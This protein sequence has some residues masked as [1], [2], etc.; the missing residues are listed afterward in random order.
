LRPGAVVWPSWGGDLENTHEGHDTTINA[1]NVHMLRQKWVVRT[2]GNISAIPTLSETR[3][4]VPDWGAP[5][6]G[7]STLYAIDRKSGHVVGKRHMRNYSG[8]VL[9]ALT[10]SS[11]A[12]AGDLMVF[13]DV[14]SQA[15]SLLDL[16]GAHGAMVYAVERSTGRLVWKTK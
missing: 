11:P 5:Y 12:L 7:E 8:N 1:Q 10:R 6:L 13:G 16:P 3:V 2:R 15:S 4:Y 14:R 9:N